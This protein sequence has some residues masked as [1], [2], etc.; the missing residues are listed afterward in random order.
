MHSFSVSPA[1][2]VTDLFLYIEKGKGKHSETS[3]QTRNVDQRMNLA[4]PEL[5]EGIK[6][7]VFEHLLFL[8]SQVLLFFVF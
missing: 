8:L 5:A 1:L 2:V 7:E 6:Q 4:A 3:C